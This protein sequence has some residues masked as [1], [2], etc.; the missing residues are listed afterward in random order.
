MARKRIVADIAFYGTGTHG[1][2]YIARAVDGRIFGDG[3][4]IKWRSFTDALWAACDELYRHN[5]GVAGSRIRVFE[6]GGA[7]MAVAD[8]AA[9]G[10]WGD[11]TWE[12]APVYVVTV[13]T[14][15]AASTQPE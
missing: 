4:P 15:L 6:P 13:E 10:Y 12:A 2:G 11:L 8:L 3:M 14:I 7:R 5:Y 9:P 1:A